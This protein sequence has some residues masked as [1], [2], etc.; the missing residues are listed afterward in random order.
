MRSCGVYFWGAG[1]KGSHLVLC[2]GAEATKRTILLQFLR[3]GKLERPKVVNAQKD[4]SFGKGRMDGLYNSVVVAFEVHA[5][6]AFPK[7]GTF[8]CALHFNKL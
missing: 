3:Q 5:R 6:G 1:G 7:N 2:V 4:A 8:V